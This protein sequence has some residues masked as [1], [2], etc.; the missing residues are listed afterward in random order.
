MG[1]ALS[2]GASS[3]CSTNISHCPYYEDYF[4]IGTQ[5]NSENMALVQLTEE[6]LFYENKMLKK[7][8]LL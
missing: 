5:E 6:K 8:I 2:D 1:S 7:H 3:T 4:Y